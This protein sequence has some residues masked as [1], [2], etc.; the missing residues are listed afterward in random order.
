MVVGR[1]STKR[2]GRYFLEAPLR[3]PA[4]VLA[5][6]A[7]L[8]L[9]SLGVALLLP[10]RFRAAV[11]LE[12]VGRDPDEALLAERGIDVAGRRSQLVRERVTELGLVEN[13][14]RELQ[15]YSGEGAPVAGDAQARR[16]RSELQLRP[17][18]SSSFA[19]EFVH[20]DPGMAAAV[21]NHLAAALVASGNAGLDL[22]LLEARVVEAHR[23]LSE[24]AAAARR[25]APPPPLERL[26][27]PASRPSS[28]PATASSVSP[29]ALEAYDQAQR[30]YQR[31]LEEWQ[32]A[33][34]RTATSASGPELR[35]QLLRTAAVPQAAEPRHPILFALLGALAGLVGGLVVALAAEYRDDRV[36]GPED[37][38][39]ILPVPL[40]AMLPEARARDLRD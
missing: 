25:V 28:P 16:L 15:P 29:V 30:A 2:K 12:A 36:K 27:A 23:L 11:L 33:A 19:V 37:L 9:A 6:L 34:T 13:L 24:K 17:I 39:E 38:R 1:A 22:P 21:V 5:P 8:T 35:F 31:L 4:L 40:L 3:R 26:A 32:A 7:L 10:A 20:R 18:A 14:A